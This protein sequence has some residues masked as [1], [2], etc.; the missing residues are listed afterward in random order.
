MFRCEWN[1]APP[2]TGGFNCDC[3]IHIQP[4]T[5]MQEFICAP[6]LLFIYGKVTATVTVCQYFCSYKH[7]G[8][9][10]TLFCQKRTAICIFVA[11]KCATDTMLLRQQG[12]AV[13]IKFGLHQFCC[14]A[15]HC[16]KFYSP[17][18]VRTKCASRAIVTQQYM[19]ALHNA[20]LWHTLYEWS[21]MQV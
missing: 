5:G 1:E 16:C 17:K 21:T 8:W 11:P 2:S 12:S 13:R 20:Q 7:C 19:R 15:L 3:A 10:G 9:L 6:L 14:A 4:K 18:Y